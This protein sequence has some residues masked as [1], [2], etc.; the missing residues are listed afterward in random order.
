[1]S[2]KQPKLLQSITGALDLPKEL[3]F[4]LPGIIMTSNEEIYIENY[5]GIVSYS[6]NEIQLNTSKM[7]IKISGSRLG[8]SRIAAE[9]ITVRGKIKSLEFLG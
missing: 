7:P 6:E 8:I 1:M 3:V 4:N 9:E 5:R 2:K